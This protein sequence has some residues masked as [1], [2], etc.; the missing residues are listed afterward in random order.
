MEDSLFCSNIIY[1]KLE[2]RDIYKKY[3]AGLIDMESEGVQKV[4][5][6]YN[7]PFVALKII[8]D[9]SDTNLPEDL[10]NFYF[11]NKKLKYLFK[12]PFY[13]FVLIKLGL[14]FFKAR[15]VLKKVCNILF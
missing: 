3:Q 4:C 8:L 10:V 9:D 14:S 1:K 5:L 13:L 11:K 12:F 2:K 6:K 15:I 7:I